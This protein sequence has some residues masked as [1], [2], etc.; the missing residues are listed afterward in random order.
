MVP[1]DLLTSGLKRFLRLGYIATTVSGLVLVA[2]ITVLAVDGPPLRRRDVINDWITNVPN[3]NVSASLLLLLVIATLLGAYFVGA[4]ARMLAVA[5]FGLVTFL[6]NVGHA[7]IENWR[8]R[9]RERKGHWITP[10]GGG[11]AEYFPGPGR[12]EPL[13]RRLV[14]FYYGFRAVVAPIFPLKLKSDAVWAGLEGQFG[15]EG[16]TRVLG[17][18]P[19]KVEPGDSEARIGATF[20]Y[21]QCQGRSKTDPLRAG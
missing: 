17:R 18:H 7:R 13:R 1:W 3:W 16:L 19:I 12:W 10:E 14:P 2:E 5:A 15:H 20:G 9:R 4:T 11:P 8:R 6:Y 21:C